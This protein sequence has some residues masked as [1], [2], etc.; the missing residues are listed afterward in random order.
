MTRDI[1]DL[2]ADAV[3]ERARSLGALRPTPAAF[4]LTRIR[5]RRRRI[6]RH[7]VQAGVGAA[8]VG[9]VAVGAWFGT[10]VDRPP[11]FPAQTPSST[12]G[13][14]SG[15]TSAP[16]TG[17]PTSPTPTVPVTPTVTPGLPSTS[18]APDGLLARTGPGWVLAAYRSTP[19][20]GTG[21]AA[22]VHAVVAIAPDGTRYR[23][24]DLPAGQDVALADWRGGQD[25]ALVSYG[26]S[27]IDGSFTGWLDLRTGALTQVDPGVPADRALETVLPDG[28]QLWSTNLTA[29]PVE[30]WAVPQGGPARLVGQLADHWTSLRVSPAGARVAALTPTADAVLVLDVT[31]G[32]RRTANLAVPGGGCTLLGW[33]DETSVLVSCVDYAGPDPIVQRNPRL[34]R[35]DVDA[36]T[37]SVL[38]RLGVGQPFAL[39][40]VVGVTVAP[41]TVAFSAYTLDAVIPMADVCPNS[42]WEWTAGTLR[43]VALPGG[44]DTFRL[45]AAGG[46]LYLA[47][48]SG[49]TVGTGAPVLSHLAPD[50][51]TTVLAPA[52]EPLVG[53]ETST[54]LSWV[55]AR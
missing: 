18:L 24:A 31:T 25:R 9:A 29:G 40:G 47:S 16:S 26:P 41:G 13:P 6:V 14:T 33:L 32:A 15:P 12:P 21:S 55:V 35:V 10:H 34:V 49:C 36:G 43:Q 27:G 23:L 3:E 46:D 28:T 8:A 44:G 7:S 2:L 50:G 48:S 11:A 30:L 1:A 54:S 39:N 37:T 5:I 53:V 38:A 17:V 45:A 20:N 22:A 52:P 4:A 42:V 51:S 19:A